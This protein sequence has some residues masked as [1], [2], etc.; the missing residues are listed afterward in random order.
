MSANVKINVQDITRVEGHGNIVVN[1]TDGKIEELRLEI[2]ESPRF[3]EAMLLGRKWNEATH[4][5]CRICGIC[6]CGHTTASL[7]ACEAALGIKP[8]EQT[9]LLRRLLFDGEQLESHI[10]HTYFLAAPDFLGVPSVLPLAASHPDVV[11]RALRLKRLANDICIVV[12]GRHIH[13]IAACVNGFTKLPEL[14]ELEDL[15]ERLIAARADLDET[16][17]LFKTLQLPDF[18][19]E[20]CFV[21]LTDPNC[22]AWFTGDIKFSAT[23]ETIPVKDYQTK[24]R[25][26]VVPHSHAKHAEVNGKSYMVGALARV[27]NN[28]DQLCPA[29]KAAAEALGL[30]VP[31]YNP[32]MNNVAQVAESFEVVEDAIG[33]ID[34]LLARGLKQED[35]TVE[36]KAGRGVGAADVPRGLLIHD[37]TWDAD[38]VI[39]AA[40]LMI[41]TNQ[42]LNN[43]EQDMRALVPRILDKSEAEM[44]LLLEMLVRAYDPCISCATHLLKVEFVR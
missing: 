21:S 19:R 10:L 36:V 5:T 33:V 25:E 29:A 13:P 20:T 7:N 23:G 44:T 32:F 15:R 9:H 34:E 14:A 28:Y 4:I 37:Y 42:N 40:N 6:S 16:V 2:T 35:R 22:Y 26:F 24:I 39:T 30:Q 3:Y 11:K 43:I 1:V 27:N 31:C 8:S 12:A 18:Q 38:G 17:A 41:P